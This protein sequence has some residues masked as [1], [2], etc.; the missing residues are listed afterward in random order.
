MTAPPFFRPCRVAAALAAASLNC[1]GMDGTL[2]GKK[3]LG[4]PTQAAKARSSSRSARL[5]SWRKT[6]S[7]ACAS[8][9]PPWPMARFTFAQP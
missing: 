2:R 9:H 1:F 6:V 3:G 4:K 8:P 7:K 5:R